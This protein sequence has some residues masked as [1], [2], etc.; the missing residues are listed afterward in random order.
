[1]TRFALH[2]ALKLIMWRQGLAPLVRESPLHGPPL[3]PQSHQPPEV[4]YIEA[5]SN[6]EPP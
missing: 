3:L 6:A 1:M 2:K 4:N 5:I